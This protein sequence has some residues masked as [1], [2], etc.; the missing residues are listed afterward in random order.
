VEPGVYSFDLKS[1]GVELL[2][3]P[4]VADRIPDDVREKVEALRQGVI[5]GEITI[6]DE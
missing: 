5:S 3:C 4:E 6:A 2:M 1:G